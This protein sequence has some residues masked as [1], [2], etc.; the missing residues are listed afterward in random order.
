MERRPTAW[1][2]CYGERPGWADLH[3]IP[4]LRA[5]RRLGCDVTAYPLLL[6]VERACVDLDAFR[7]ARP[8][9]HPDF[10]GEPS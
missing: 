6:G 9:H 5:G 4:Q 8:E 1:T 2:F 3:L 10:T 7:L